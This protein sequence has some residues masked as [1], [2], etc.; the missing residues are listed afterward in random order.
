MSLSLSALI[1]YYTVAAIAAV[2]SI[3]VA[4]TLLKNGMLHTPATKLLLALHTLLLVEE[5]TVLPS[6]FDRAESICKLVEFLHI[7]SSLAFTSTVGLL[8]VSYRYHF[9]EDTNDVMKTI[10]KYWLYFIVLFP[11]LVM[12]PFLVSIITK[13]DSV[14]AVGASEWCTIQTSGTVLYMVSFVLYYSIIWCILLFSTIFLSCTMYEVYVVDEMVGMKLMSTTGM[15]A[16]ISIVSW[17]PRTCIRM[18]NFSDEDPGNTSWIVAYMPVFISGML[19]T[20]VF[21]S[22]KK[23]LLLFD[24][25]VAEHQFSWEPPSRLQSAESIRLSTESSV[26]QSLLRENGS[27]NEVH[28]SDELLT[29]RVIM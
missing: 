28:R 9:F 4:A 3:F 21:L 7:Y 6:L 11:F 25:S 5:I 18:I 27:L 2:C 16:I 15:Y 24:H 14:T 20:V 22:E 19:L 17:I 12:I 29:R 8:V 13:E 23:A 10:E 26:S 1:I